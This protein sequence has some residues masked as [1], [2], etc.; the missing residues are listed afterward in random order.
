MVPTWKLGQS[1][2]FQ[3]IVHLTVDGS[4]WE[5]S[6]VAHKGRSFLWQLLP[7]AGAL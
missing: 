7:C 6:A 4:G 1:A 5:Y 3:H 2:C